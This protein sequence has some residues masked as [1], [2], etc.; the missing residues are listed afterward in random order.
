[1][2]GERNAYRILVVKSWMAP[3]WKTRQF[4]F[5][6]DCCSSE[7]FV[8]SNDMILSKGLVRLCEEPVGT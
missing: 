1:M 3:S 6:N 8:A 5:L 2:W 4:M 7:D